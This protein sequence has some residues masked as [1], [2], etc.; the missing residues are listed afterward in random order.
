[1]MTL[2]ASKMYGPKGIGCLAVKKHVA[3][4]RSFLAA[5]RSM[6][7]EPEQKMCRHIV[8]FAEALDCPKCEKKNLKAIEQS[9]LKDYFFENVIK[10]YQRH[11]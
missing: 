2:D 4:S 5:D 6:D 1:M 8:G 7:C 3:S 11:Y 9:K 10:K